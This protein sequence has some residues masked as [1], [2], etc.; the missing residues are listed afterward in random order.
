MRNC[1]GSQEK[2]DN[3]HVSMDAQVGDEGEAAPGNGREDQE[4][5]DGGLKAFSNEAARTG[6][7]EAPEV[8]GE[9][10]LEADP[11]H[12]RPQQACFDGLEFIGNESS[13]TPGVEQAGE[14]E[15]QY[16]AQQQ[17]LDAADPQAF[18]RGREVKTPPDSH[19]RLEYRPGNRK[20]ED[21][22]HL[23]T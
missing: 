15:G 16:Y 21:R 5:G 19:P 17:V 9:P 10:R 14:A 2:C 13:G 6:L 3:R 22:N 1:G 23:V 11:N 7:R 20:G 18:Q 12:R 4:K 8:E